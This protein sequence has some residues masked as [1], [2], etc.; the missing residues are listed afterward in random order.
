M[1]M[2]YLILAELQIFS[3]LLM[4]MKPASLTPAFITWVYRRLPQVLSVAG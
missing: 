1:S 4:I 3:L 2:I